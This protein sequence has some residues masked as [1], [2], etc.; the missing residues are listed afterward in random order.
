MPVTRRIAAQ[1]RPEKRSLGFFG[2]RLQSKTKG[3]TKRRTS[4]KKRM[5]FWSAMR[6]SGGRYIRKGGRFGPRVW[7]P[8]KSPGYNMRRQSGGRARRAGQYRS[9]WGN[10]VQNGKNRTG[11]F[12]NRYNHTHATPELKFH[13]ITINTNPLVGPAGSIILDSAV[14][15][16]A[17]SGESQRIGRQI[18]VKKFSMKFT[19]T[20]LSQTTSGNA[21]GFARI[22]VYCDKQA[23]GATATVGGI[24]QSPLTM[25]SYRDLE[26]VN[27]FKILADRKYAL[28]P[29]AGVGNGTTNI[30]SGGYTHD[31]IHLNL[32]LP[33]E[34]SLTTAAIT[35]IKSNN[36]GILAISHSGRVKLESKVRI[37]FEG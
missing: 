28:S 9:R 16:A 25:M 20:F 6:Q 2:L 32:N 37:R 22:I 27:R 10:I 23:N 33:I 35:E 14:K 26:N 12:Y 24:L 4:P 29:T 15:I 13:D 36:I 31:E 30:F 19:L 5:S 34:Y 3:S 1:E 7:T 21:H 18:L 11:G 17:G 8:Y